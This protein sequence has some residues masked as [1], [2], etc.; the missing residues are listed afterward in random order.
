MGDQHD[1]DDVAAILESQGY[2]LQKH[3]D[4]PYLS[5]PPLENESTAGDALNV[6]EH[7]LHAVNALRQLADTGDKPVTVAGTVLGGDTEHGI[8]R[9]EMVA[10]CFD[11]KATLTDSGQGDQREVIERTS[12]WLAAI[13]AYPALREMIELLNSDRDNKYHRALELIIQDCKQDKQ[14]AWKVVGC[15]SRNEFFDVK[16]TLNIPRHENPDYTP[17]MSQKAAEIH[18]RNFIQAWLDH[19]S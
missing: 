11:T 14:Q 5:G 2:V 3:D 16:G 15:S 13:D 17:A 6:V 7:V 8:V 10:M 1:I 4:K 9:P 12:R 19:K 18:A